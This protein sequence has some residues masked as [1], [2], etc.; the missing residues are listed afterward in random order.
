MHHFF[1]FF[2]FSTK[3][4]LVSLYIPLWQPSAI[5]AS[6]S[7]GMFSNPGI[8][9]D[10]RLTRYEV[11]ESTGSDL[12]STSSYPYPAVTKPKSSYVL[13]NA[14]TATSSH[15]SPT[16]PGKPN[17]LTN[18]AVPTRPAAHHDSAT[19]TS[20]VIGGI[21]GGAV[22]ALVLVIAAVLVLLVRR[23]YRRQKQ[24]RDYS[25]GSS[26]PKSEDLEDRA[27]VH[28]QASLT[29]SL[30]NGR[31]PPEKRNPL[32]RLFPSKLMQMIRRYQQ[33]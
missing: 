30:P 21:V 1:P 15:A 26:P 32:T 10:T 6:K 33:A 7:S 3:Y 5:L 13:S 24:A 31:S 8:I 20:V 19:L 22:G 2:F 18:S 14:F 27:N 11:P 4:Q 29:S 16:L 17:S 28:N 9:K 25:G 23:K 12:Y